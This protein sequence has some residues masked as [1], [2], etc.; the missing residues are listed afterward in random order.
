[1]N[2]TIVT[3]SNPRGRPRKTWLEY[4][5][6]DLKVKGLEAS[7]RENRTACRW[8]LNPNSRQVDVTMT[9]CNTR[10]R[11]TTHVILW[12]KEVVTSPWQNMIKQFKITIY[13]LKRGSDF[14]I[15]FP[16]NWPN[17]DELLQRYLE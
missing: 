4:K 11:G 7:L 16:L 1:M 2:K 10:T 5:R 12:K 13:S 17:D 14:V 15:I 3:G 8:V 9:K 6:N